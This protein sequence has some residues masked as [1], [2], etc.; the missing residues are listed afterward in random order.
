MIRDSVGLFLEEGRLTGVILGGRDRLAHFVVEGAE[1]PAGALDAELRVRA[2]RAPRIGVGLDRR[3]VVVKALELPGG[4][5]SDLGQMVS[6]ELERHVP[7]PADEICSS[8]VELPSDVGQSRRVLVTAVARRALDRPLDLLARAKRRPAGIM[9]ASHE[10][11]GLLSRAQPSRRAVWA[12]RHG[13]RTDLLLLVGSTLLMSRSVVVVDPIGLAREIGR[14]LPLVNWEKCDVVWLSGDDTAA[15]IS[16][17]DLATGLDTPVSTPPYDARPSG[18]IAALPQESHGGGLLALAAA[19]GARRPAFDLLPAALRSW[20][21]TRPHVVS[22]S[23]VCATALLGLTFAITHVALSER[24]L[25]RV[26]DEIRRLDPEAK[27]VETLAAE[28]DRSHRLLAGLDSA[29]RASL[30]ALPILRDLTETLPVTAW[31]QTLNMDHEGVELIGQADAAS[32][33]IPLLEASRLLERVEFT[34]PVTQLQGREQFRI[35]AAWEA[36]APAPPA[37]GR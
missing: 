23:I 32:Q 30:P 21:L 7:F 10:L 31:L 9:V 22:A 12:H 4:N 27:A 35:R 29:R 1:D 36:Q 33:L 18:V 28:R 3:A 16:D 19:L 20:K 24:Y 13:S 8:W 6:F 15:W 25:G 2:L 37:G 14:S 17:H 34:S 5:G 11:P 26:N